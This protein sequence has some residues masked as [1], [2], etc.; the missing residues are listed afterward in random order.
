MSFKQ[1]PVLAMF[2]VS[3]TAYAQK[4]G[5]A[6]QLRSITTNYYADYLAMNPMA[7]TS[8]GEIGYDDKME[9]NISKD[10]INAGIRL[11][12]RYLDSLKAVNTTDLTEADKLTARI[13]GFL[14]ERELDGFQRG[15]TTSCMALRPV[16]QFVFSFPTSFATNAAGTGSIPF[17]TVKNY[18]GFLKRLPVFAKWVDIAIQNMNEGLTKGN[19]SPRAS[20]MKVP[21]QLR[22]LFETETSQH[23][24]YKPALNL[25]DSFSV[26]DKQRIALAYKNAVD[27]IVK[28]AYKKLHD[29]FVNVYIPGSR[30]SSGLLA[31][32]GGKEEYR[33]W[34][35]FWNSQDI[36]PDSV[37][38]YGL[39]EV[40][41]I[42]KNMDSIKTKTGFKGDLPAF[43]DYVKTEKKF[44]PFTSEQQVLDRYRSFQ[45]RMAPSIS[46]MFNLV[47]KSKF[48]I[49][50]TE[51][52]RQA[53]ANAQYMR[54]SRDGSRPGIF[55]EVIPD[56]LT[57]NEVGMET[58]FLHEAIPG[59]HFQVALQQEMTL[60]AFRGSAFFGAF[61]EGWGLY[62]ETLG[63]ELGMFSDP[64]Q[65]LGHLNANM[66]RSVRLV[67]DVGLHHKG[68]SREKAIEYV[69][70][71]QPVTPEVAAQRI[72]RYMVTPGQAQ[73]YKIGEQKI[74]FLR[75]L[76][77]QKLGEAFDIR[78]FHDQVLKDG[79]MP[80]DIL[81]QKIRTWIDSKLK[82]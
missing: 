40:A 45:E 21:A 29:Y 25:P 48:E 49:R 30:T 23:V 10:Y 8:R 14:L 59:H 64:Y 34:M 3:A 61:S 71:N 81:D 53:G 11:N 70:A 69:L 5:A 4:P 20:M 56:A 38:A 51:K 67:V 9:I 65:Y 19:I 6:N 72:E 75:N 74:L 55:Y 80:L 43:F 50:A 73:S 35:R 39:S 78:E 24:F 44:F 16:D 68:W 33:Y 1:L 60:P 66:E 58:L 28:P 47:P 42:R 2:F 22:P 15:I 41:R 54:P 31:N 77:Q 52:F 46:R 57:Y 37:F 63:L 62:A 18:D 36:D 79:A 17:R 82:S 26:A 13:F 27:N 7:A 12:H 32:A 76:S